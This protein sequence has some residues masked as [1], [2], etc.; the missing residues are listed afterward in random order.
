MA[1]HKSFIIYKD[2]RVLV[3]TLEDTSAGR[4]FKALFAYAC[5]GERSAL[6]DV[7]QIQALY[8][9]MV[10]QIEKNEEKYQQRCKKNAENGAK[11]GRP[12]TKKPKKTEG[13]SENQMLARGCEINRS[14]AK[15]ADNDNDKDKENDNEKDH[16]NVNDRRRTGKD[17]DSPSILTA[18]E[19]NEL[20]GLS[21]VGSV[22]K[23][24]HKL[25]EWQ[26]QTHKRCKD[27]FGT[28]K[29]WI[30][31]DGQKQADSHSYDLEAIEK[32]ALNYGLNGGGEA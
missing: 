30:E 26:A 24:V 16:D 32:F 1:E 6:E 3:D 9:F 13:F 17:C 27:P 5:D 28:I 7:Q 25:N 12:S 15:K 19:Y 31:Q 10:Q 4:L 22:C 18:A 11:G 8:E 29:T 2:W 14:Q 20:V 23:Y 21:S